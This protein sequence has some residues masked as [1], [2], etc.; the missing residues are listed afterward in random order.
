MGLTP[1]TVII[2]VKS[3]PFHDSIEVVIRG[4]RLALGRRMAHHIFVNVN[5]E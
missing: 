5:R 2:V 1:G 4:C 3:A